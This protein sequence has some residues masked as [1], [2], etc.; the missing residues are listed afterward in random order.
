MR[1]LKIPRDELL[2]RCANTFKRLGYHGTTM[3]AL[4][5]A[6]GLTKASFYHHY[7]SKE[8]LLVDVLAW[9]HERLQQSLF[10]IAFDEALPVPERFIRMGRKAKKLFQDDSIGCLMGV[11][12]VD[13]TYGKVELM[14]P[15][16]R[17]MDDWA[18][19]FTQLF[20]AGYSQEQAQRLA[21]QLVADY[22]GAILLARI[23]GDLSYIDAVTERGLR[24]LEEA[25][26]PS[27][28]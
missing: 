8:S 19:A 10:S 22:E 7:P 23:Y 24:Q 2:Q 27:R 5:T 12:A 15:I 4:S 3:D 11:M 25:G 17:F 26:A 9:T 6:C 18:A 13:S 16:R 21:R 28:T 20:G 1:P 14:E